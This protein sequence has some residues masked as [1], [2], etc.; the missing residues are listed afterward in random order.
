MGPKSKAIKD[1][2]P[3][4]TSAKKVITF[5]HCLLW[6]KRKK[7]LATIV[8][9]DAKKVKLTN[10]AERVIFWEMATHPRKITINCFYYYICNA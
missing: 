4:L 10:Q 6:K 5:V 9:N 7:V 1:F 8:K 3:Q 2:F